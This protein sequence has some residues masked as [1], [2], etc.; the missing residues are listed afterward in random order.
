MDLGRPP[1][2]YL[3]SV[4]VSGNI[5]TIKGWALDPDTDQSIK[6][7]VYVN[8]AGAAYTADKTRADVG[9]AFPGFGDQHG[10]SE[11]IALPTGSS[12]ICAYAINTGNGGNSTLGCRVATVA[13]IELDHGKSPFGN[14]ESVV[15]QSDSIA[16][17]GWAI[18]PD[19]VEPI[20]VHVYVDGVGYATT[21]NA[22]RPDVGAAYPAS[23]PF[24][25]F[26]TTVPATAGAHRVCVY[27]IDSGGGNN[28][29][30]ACFDVTV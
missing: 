5:A 23:G 3:E 27:M 25:G 14:I 24:H 13:Q 2:G 16:L 15:P 1:T 10:F 21:A 26:A 20:S 22:Q 7:H 8:S 30:L 9:K 29:T 19:T 4:E 17:T 6:V 18:D 11:Q 28:P 12:T